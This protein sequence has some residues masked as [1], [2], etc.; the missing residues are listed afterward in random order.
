M[1]K[2]QWRRVKTARAD[3]IRLIVKIAFG[4]IVIGIAGYSVVVERFPIDRST[5]DELRA[6]L[7]Q[8]EAKLRKMLFR[9]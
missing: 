4:L 1:S 3:W 9:P 6:T 7:S 5:P 8:A 2:P